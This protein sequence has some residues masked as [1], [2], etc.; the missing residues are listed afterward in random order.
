MVVQLQ[1]AS[2]KGFRFLVPD[3]RT[4]GGQKTASHEFPG[5]NRRSVQDLGQLPDTFVVVA[6]VHGDNYIADVAR[7][8]QILSEGG[9]GDFVHPSQGTFRVKST[10]YTLS[11][12]DADKG[13]A[14]FEINFATASPDIQ[15]VATRSNQGGVARQAET[16]KSALERFIEAFYKVVNTLS[17]NFTDAV[18]QLEEIAEAFEQNA[19]QFAPDT[20]GISTFT[21]TV[22]SFND[23]ATSL[24]QNPDTLATD[25]FGLFDAFDGIQITSGNSFR[26]L[27]SFFSFGDDDVANSNNTFGLIQRT[28]NRDLLRI[29]VQAGALAESYREATLIEFD[30]VP[31]IEQVSEELDAQYRKVKGDI[32]DESMEEMA[33]LRDLVRKFFDDQRLVAAQIIEL[34]LPVLPAIVQAQNLYGE[35]AQDR[36]DDLIEVN[37]TKDTAFLGGRDTKVLTA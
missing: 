2:Y 25:L 14:R 37:N 15:P 35:D 19:S 34:N 32:D 27:I 13:R 8:K 6:I 26:E 12:S 1:P 31:E 30:T 4:Q 24:V 17:G 21:R 20:P 10:G 36:V 22:Q 28:N 29:S 5:S 18:D 16:V 33:T 23:S 9:F 11:E 7:L 3:T